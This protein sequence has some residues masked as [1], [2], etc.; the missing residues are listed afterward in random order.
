MKVL[1]DG[2]EYVPRAT[3]QPSEASN[4]DAERALGHLVQLVYLYGISGM[5]RGAR[6]CIWD[7]IRAL[8]PSVAELEPEDF[9]K[10]WQT[11]WGEREG[12]E[13]DGDAIP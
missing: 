1:I 5:Q 10:L 4:E 11:R 7:A 6:G 13:L 2:L 3:V 12:D 9:G 8:D